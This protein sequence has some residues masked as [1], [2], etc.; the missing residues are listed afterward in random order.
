MAVT[1]GASQGAPAAQNPAYRLASRRR[2]S[3]GA[4]PDAA[5]AQQIATAHRA[6]GAESGSFVNRSE[7]PAF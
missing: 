4:P 7:D 3:A 6:T 2:L 5:S 1:A